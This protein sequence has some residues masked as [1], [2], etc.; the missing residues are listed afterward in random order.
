[1]LADECKFLLVGQLSAI[2]S[3]NGDI[4]E[5]VDK[6]IYLCSNISS[7]ESDVTRHIDNAWTAIDWLINK[8]GYLPSYSRVSTIVCLHHLILNE[9]L[10]EKARWELDMW[11]RRAG[12][13][14]RIKEKL[15]YG[16]LLMDS[17]AGK[18]T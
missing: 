2:F 9:V 10:K 1:M 7:T 18:S 11:V 8:T 17:P 3:L 5:L 14:L 6:F 16:Q 13:C 4:F 12:Q 15:S